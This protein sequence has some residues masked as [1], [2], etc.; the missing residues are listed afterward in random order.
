MTPSRACERPRSMLRVWSQR[1][2]WGRCSFWAALRMALH[3]LCWRNRAG[4]PAIGE[5]RCLMLVAYFHSA[6]LVLFV[7]PPL[8]CARRAP[9]LQWLDVGIGVTKGAV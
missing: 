4:Y 8:C 5:P 2:F 7:V 1:R 3:H 6:H 9:K